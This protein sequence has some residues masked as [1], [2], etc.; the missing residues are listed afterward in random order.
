MRR[1]FYLIPLFLFSIGSVHISVIQDITYVPVGA[2]K[3]MTAYPSLIKGYENGFLI[4]HDQTKMLYDDGQTNKSHIELLDNPDLKDMFVYCYPTGRT[5]SPP[6]LYC[7]P[8][9]V[10]KEDFFMKMYGQTREE[11]EKHLTEIVWCPQTV[12]Q[13]LLVTTINGVDKQL[14]KVSEEL[15][16]HPEW[17]RYIRAMGR[18]F[19]WRVIA[20]TNR[21]S[22]HSFGAAFDLSRDY[23]DYWQRD[24]G[25]ADESVP[26]TYKNRFL[27]EIVEIFEKYGFIWGGK[28]Y[29][30]DTMHFEYRPE[31]LL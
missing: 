5:T 14:L 19:N 12:G 17:E 21:L 16:K 27:L 3:L 26:I 9:R 2:Q 18:G 7:D 15:D 22:V 29:H 6:E 13:T 28:W 11:V 4:F 24:Y 31:L 20:G 8:G 10:R 23:S 30:Y 1:F 25:T